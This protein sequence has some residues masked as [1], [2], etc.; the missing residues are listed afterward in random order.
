MALRFDDQVVV[1]TGAG[2]GLG[3]EYAR[4]FASRGAKVVVND[5]GGSRHGGGAGS[6]AADAVVQG[7]LDAG[8]QAVAD[9]HSVEHGEKIIETAI[10]AYGRV[11]VLINNAGILRD[12]TI[13]NMTDQDWDVIMAVHLT[14]A[15]KTT[16][17]AWP[18]FRKQ[19]YG[20]VINT[21]SA[22]GLFGNFGQGNYAAAKLALVGFTETLAL[23][24]AKYNI[25]A[26]V[27]S[28]AAASRL[29]ETVWP[30]EM[31][32][33]MK[34]AW[35][36]P[37]VATLVHAS[38][39]ESGSIFEA[40]AGHYAKIRWERARGLLLR[41]DETLT[42]GSLLRSWSEV[43]DFTD[44][45][46][47]TRA[48]VADSMD[49][50]QQAMKLPPSDAG[51]E[52]DFAGK[53]ALVTGGG[54]GLGRAYAFLFAKLGAKV[55]VND[56][57]GADEVAA[58]IRD[59]GGEAVAQTTSVEDGATVVKAVVNAYGR[60]DIVVN[61]AGILRDKAFTNMTDD[62]WFPVINV[63]LRG[64]YQIMK[65][66][67][68]HMLKQK[69]GRIV[70][71]T[72]TSGIYG[73]F[74]QANYAAAKTGILG[75]SKT[76]AREGA[77]YNIHVNVV[78]PSA[79]TNMT[80]TVRPEEEVQAMRPEFVAP[81]VALLCSD[82]CPDPTGGLYEAGTG[83]FA[84]TRFQRARGADFAHH[85]GVPEVEAVQEVSWS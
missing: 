79:G 64:T 38:S 62:L 59:A 76:A 3:K 12:I 23:E 18:H 32:D 66:A 31:M 16:R 4:L 42:P 22:S 78:A 63:H 39:K 57:V 84:A 46:H 73:S 17:A 19:R 81:L 13:K 36:V 34:P 5:L 48:S 11:D 53:V 51:E 71:I 58:Q 67:W 7:I 85:A 50:L 25:T 41:P 72:S 68:P 43:R 20:R 6:K 29:T 24:G 28:P 26:N 70:N 10:S 61:N 35:V 80:R 30:P 33:V 2:A 21:S 54:E 82:R 37:L 45:E 8:G 40:G 69:Y 75:L 77:K 65:A 52:F 83:W 14:G 44:A 56:I 27:L 55:V 60:I 49:L 47:P 1:V 74:G 15:Y 9:Y